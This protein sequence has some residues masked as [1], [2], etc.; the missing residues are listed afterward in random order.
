[1][2][3]GDPRVTRQPV[4]GSVSESTSTQASHFGHT[5]STQTL[6]TVS[7]PSEA[8]HSSVD[9]STMPVSADTSVGQQVRILLLFLFF[10]FEADNSPHL[11]LYII[12]YNFKKLLISNSDFYRA[13]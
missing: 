1:M 3:V 2:A 6:G 7:S 13:L 5:A 12:I 10:S 11:L 4:S 9:A 8:H